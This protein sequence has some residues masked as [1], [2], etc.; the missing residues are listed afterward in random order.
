[1]YKLQIIHSTSEIGTRCR[2]VFNASEINH[3]RYYFWE[4]FWYL[5]NTLTTVAKV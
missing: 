5:Y 4:E 3:W 2:C 1:M